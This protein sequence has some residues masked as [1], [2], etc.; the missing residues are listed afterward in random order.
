MGDWFLYQNKMWVLEKV[1][2]TLVLKKALGRDKEGVVLLR[3]DYPIPAKNSNPK[4]KQPHPL[5]SPEGGEEEISSSPSSSSADAPPPSK[6]PSPL[7]KKRKAQQSV[8]SSASEQSSQSQ[9]KRKTKP[10]EGPE[11]FDE[12][13]L[14]QTKLYW[15]FYHHQSGLVITEWLRNDYPDINKLMKKVKE[16]NGNDLGIYFGIRKER[17][18]LMYSKIRTMLK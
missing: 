8:A 16:M 10:S 4:E 14:V 9:K 5:P 18:N 2:R 3:I 7:A 1:K 15:Y 17:M 6:Q 13:D 11:P 12:D